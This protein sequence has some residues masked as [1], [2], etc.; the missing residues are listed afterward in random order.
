MTIT[1]EMVKEL[2]QKTG[3]G[4]MECKSALQE[5]GGSLEVAIT[6]LRKRGLSS[7]ARKAGRETKEGLIGTYVHNG[8]IGVMVEVN[9]E[10]DF[11][12]RNAEF[13]TLVHD[14][15]MQIA[16]AEPRFVRKEDVTGEVIAAERAIHEEQA[17]ATGKPQGVLDKIVEGRMAKFYSEVCLL[18]Q[19]F[20]KNPEINVKAYLAG[21]IQKIGEN[22]QVRRFIRYKVG[23]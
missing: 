22:I 12:A 1:A 6:I 9:C 3:V 5:A 10:T 4:L 2:R 21:Y 18:E 13:Q 7:V 20:I 14:I 23:E 16:A 19:P 11:V 8:K 15:A 17:R